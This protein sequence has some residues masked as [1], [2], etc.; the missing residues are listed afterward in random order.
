M[1]EL[2]MK[3]IVACNRLDQLANLKTRFHEHFLKMKTP[4]SFDTFLYRHFKDNGHSPSKILIQPVEK[5]KYDPNSSSGLM[6]MKR[7]ITSLKWINFCAITFSLR[8]K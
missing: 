2:E 5:N 3:L 7:H 1:L 6:K 4:K 8:F